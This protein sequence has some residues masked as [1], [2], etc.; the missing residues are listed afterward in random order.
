MTKNKGVT[1]VVERPV[2]IPGIT[3]IPAGMREMLGRATEAASFQAELQIDRRDFGVGAGF[4]CC[5][6]VPVCSIVS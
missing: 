5:E 3:H 4:T 1:R 2:R 6:V